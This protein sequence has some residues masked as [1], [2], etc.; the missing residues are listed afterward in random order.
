MRAILIF[1]AG[2]LFLLLSC[3]PRVPQTVVVAL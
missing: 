1:P 2:F 3:G